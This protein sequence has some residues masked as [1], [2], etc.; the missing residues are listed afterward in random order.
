MSNTIICASKVSTGAYYLYNVEFENTFP[1]KVY[2]GHVLHPHKK[3]PDTCRIVKNTSLI[4][5]WPLLQRHNEERIIVHQ[6]LENGEKYC[7][8]RD[9][10]FRVQHT[11]IQHGDVYIPILEWSSNTSCLPHQYYI[12]CH[13]AEK[14]YV[15]TLEKYI[16]RVFQAEPVAI[17]IANGVVRAPAHIY[18]GLMEGALYRKDTCP[19]SLEELTAGIL[20]IT[21]CFHIF[22]KE[23]L[24]RSLSG[25]CPVC[26]TPYVWADVVV[27]QE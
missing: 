7:F 26:R 5:R 25:R 12:L 13:P 22:E 4:H 6:L 21:P 24:R 11:Y 18:R 19:V 16:F 1:Q 27:Y 20:C 10:Y 14:N 15:E 17:T 2:T 3:Y 8:Y 9:G 23:S